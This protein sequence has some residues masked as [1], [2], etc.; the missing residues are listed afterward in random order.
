MNYIDNVMMLVIA[1]NAIESKNNYYLT[2]YFV[3]Y[4]PIQSFLNE[5]NALFIVLFS[6]KSMLISQTRSE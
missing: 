1:S 3:F 2:F 6:R 4:V 5:R